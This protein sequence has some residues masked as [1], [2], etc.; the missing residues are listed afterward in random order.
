MRAARTLVAIQGLLFLCVAV[1]AL[2]PGPTL[3]ESLAVGIGLVVVGAAGMWWSGRSLGRALT[4]LPVPNG[5]G[6]VASGPYRFVRHPMYTALV[7]V[8][9][10]VAVGSGALWSYVSCLVLAVFFDVKT[11]VEERYLVG[12]YPGYAEYGARTGKFVP[13]LSRLRALSTD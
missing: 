4:P 5:A 1:T 7:L 12:A 6:L 13:G 3:F 10:G 8:C 2:L 9:L 11:R